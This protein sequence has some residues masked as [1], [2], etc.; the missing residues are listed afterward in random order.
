MFYFNVFQNR[1]IVDIKLKMDYGEYTMN[2]TV[3]NIT[4]NIITVYFITVN[5]TV[6][7]N[8]VYGENV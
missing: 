5:I 3:N 7:L 8:I 2:N 1:N 4:V 6:N